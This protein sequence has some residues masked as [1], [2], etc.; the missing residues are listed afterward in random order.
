MDGWKSLGTLKKAD[1]DVD[2][3]IIPGESE[4]LPEYVKDFEEALKVKRGVAKDVC[5]LCL[6]RLIHC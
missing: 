2:N 6:Y 4:I 5:Y 3:V 1:L